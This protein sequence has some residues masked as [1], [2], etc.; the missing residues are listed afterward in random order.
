MPQSH[1][2]L[3]NNGN[4]PIVLMWLILPRPLAEKARSADA[5]AV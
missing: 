2:D 3:K 4:K 1:H 5:A